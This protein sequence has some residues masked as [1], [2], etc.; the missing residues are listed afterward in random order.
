MRI[1]PV[2]SD[3]MRFYGVWKDEVMKKNY[4]GLFCYMLDHLLKN[5]CF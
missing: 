2:L 4:I 3:V 5:V 1:R